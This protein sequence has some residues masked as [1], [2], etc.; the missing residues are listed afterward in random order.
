MLSGVGVRRK[1]DWDSRSVCWR[2][3]HI[4]VHIRAFGASAEAARGR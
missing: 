4:S 1:G 2:R 3:V